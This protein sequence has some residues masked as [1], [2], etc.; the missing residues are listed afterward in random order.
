MFSVSMFPA[1]FPFMF[2]SLFPF[3]R[4]NCEDNQLGYMVPKETIL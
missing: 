1:L 4:K 2:T 3:R